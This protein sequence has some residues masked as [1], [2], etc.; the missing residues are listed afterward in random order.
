ME[1]LA[2][3]IDIVTWLLYANFTF[4]VFI[5]YYIRNKFSDTGRALKIILERTEGRLG[6]LQQDVT[7]IR[8][9]DD[10][11]DKNE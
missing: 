1:A 5:L 9:A 8:Y 10:T 6:E 11:T 7:R 2:R 3:D 4:L